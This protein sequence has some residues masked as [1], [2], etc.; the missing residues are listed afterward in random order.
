[1]QATTTDTRNQLRQPVLRRIFV[2]ACLAGASLF[3]VGGFVEAAKADPGATIGGGATA[4]VLPPAEKIRLLED[5][6]AKETNRRVKAEEDAAKRL[7]EN[8]ALTAAAKTASNERAAIALRWSE[9]RDRELQL[10]KINDRLREENERIAITVR[11]SLPIVVIVA[12]GI[13]TML[14]LTFLYLRRIATRVHSQHTLVEMREIEARLAHTSDQYNAELKRNQTL[15][16]KLA[17]LG[18]VD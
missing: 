11:L 13:L 3:A 14:I 7:T 6:L 4:R 15:R 2:L 16:N 5:E 17:D 1:M 12:A 8:N 10:Q 9:T 18:I